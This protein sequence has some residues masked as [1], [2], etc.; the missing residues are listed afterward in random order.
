MF[1]VN[2]LRLQIITLT[3]TWFKEKTEV[4]PT[5]SG[6]VLRYKNDDRSSNYRYKTRSRKYL[7]EG[8]GLIIDKSTI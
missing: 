8:I 7:C 5:P 3:T 2:G 4:P 6:I 1:L